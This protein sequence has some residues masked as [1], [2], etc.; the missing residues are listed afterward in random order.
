MTRRPDWDSYYLGIAD[1]VAVRADCTRRRVGAVVTD[2]VTRHIIATGYNGSPPGEAGCLT[3]GA[4]P[5]G[6]HYRSLY[7]GG[8]PADGILPT[9][10][11]MCG[12]GKPWPCSDAV[13]AGSSYD[14]G[15]G[16][17]IALHAEQNALVRAGTLARGAHL[18][19]TDEPCDGCWKLIRGAGIVRV[20]WYNGEYT[21][22]WFKTGPERKL[23]L[24]RW[25]RALAR[26]VRRLTSRSGKLTPS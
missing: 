18:Y 8:E 22:E 11:Q 3:D 16:A 17:C 13:E 9:F 4:C 23:M 5:R 20:K 7:K 2:P 12:C 25:M 26:S 19:L 6:R 24:W 14:T 10:G 15:P 1:S 21:G